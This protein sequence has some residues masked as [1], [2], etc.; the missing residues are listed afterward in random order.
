MENG[1]YCF[2]KSSCRKQPASKGALSRSW[3][4]GTMLLRGLAQNA[5][6]DRLHPPSL[7]KMTFP[8]TVKL[9]KTLYIS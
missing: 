6:E 4:G 1:V 8:K 7:F 5:Q 2:D 9:T 3:I